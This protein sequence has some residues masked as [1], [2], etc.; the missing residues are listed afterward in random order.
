M[1]LPRKG[2]YAFTVQAFNGALKGAPSARSN[3]VAGR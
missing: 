1:K 2:T 3:R